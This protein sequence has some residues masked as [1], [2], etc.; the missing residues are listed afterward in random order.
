[1]RWNMG[2]KTSFLD[3][4]FAEPQETI[5]S[6]GKGCLGHQSRVTSGGLSPTSASCDPTSPKS[7]TVMWTRSGWAPGGVGTPQI[8]VSALGSWK[9]GSCANIWC[10]TLLSRL[11]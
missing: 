10:F 11:I 5:E 9:Q 1:M 2:S 6:K 8:G 7:V 4:E 3:S